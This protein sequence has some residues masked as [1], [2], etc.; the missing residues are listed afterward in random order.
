MNNVGTLPA[1]T[2]LSTQRFRPL[3]IFLN[4]HLL[5]VGHEERIEE[6]SEC[7]TGNRVEVDRVLAYFDVV[8]LTV[9]LFNVLLVF[10]EFFLTD[11]DDGR[12]AE[13]LYGSQ[14]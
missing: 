12:V 7:E 11:G 4:P 10:E 6:H 1:Y 9:L 2:C 13:L 5:L 14:V 8:A 3:Q